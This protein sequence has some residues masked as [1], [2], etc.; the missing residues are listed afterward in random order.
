M[1]AAGAATEVTLAAS[2]TRSTSTVTARAVAD[3]PPWSS[4][5]RTLNAAIGALLRLTLLALASGVHHAPFDASTVSWLPA[6]QMVAE[7]ALVPMRSVPLVTAATRMAVT[8][9]STSAA[10]PPASR[11]ASEITISLSSAPLDTTLLKAL[12]VGASLTLSITSL[13]V[14]TKLVAGAWVSLSVTDQLSV[15][16]A[17]LAVGCSLGL[18]NVTV[19][20]AA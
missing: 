19:R 18:S 6:T 1:P 8:L 7:A 12:R 15:R 20:S 9:P 4:T 5:A 13:L 2:C 3:T 11:S 14:P 17:A 16:V 10:S